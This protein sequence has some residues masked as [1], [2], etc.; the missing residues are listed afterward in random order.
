MVSF[1]VCLTIVIA[2]N[3]AATNCTSKTT[4]PDNGLCNPNTNQCV[5][6]N[7][8]IE[9]GKY[10]DFLSCGVHGVVFGECGSGE[11]PDCYST[12]CPVKEDG[13]EGINCNYPGLEPSNGEAF[14][15]TSWLCGEDGTHLSCF[16][17]A[18]SVLVGVCGSGKNED[19]KTEC[20]GYHGILCADQSYFEI[21]WSRCTYVTGG[22]GDWVYC[23][24]GTVATGIQNIL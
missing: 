14:N 21:D 16:D 18:G 11:N 7:A 15:T 5:G 1:L 23:P 4:C 13:F 24:D 6:Q 12:L 20:D 2:Y 17:N 3:E 22:Y 19:C 8:T 9:C 10:G